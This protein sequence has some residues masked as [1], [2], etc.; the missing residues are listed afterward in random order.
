MPKGQRWER[1]YRNALNATD[2]YEDRKDYERIDVDF[3]TVDPFVAVRMP[4]SGSA[5]TDD[6]PDIHV[7]LNQGTSEYAVE[8][9]ATAENARLDNEEVAA[10]RRFAERT[11]AEPYVFIHVDYVG[12]FALHVNELHSTAKGFNFRKKRDADDARRLS[13]WLRDRT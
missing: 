9:K 12:D 10:L 4:S 3:A 8:I 6:L 1:N 2:P 13:T 5:T 11:G 7:W